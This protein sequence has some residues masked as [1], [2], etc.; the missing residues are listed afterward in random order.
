MIAVI[1]FMSSLD[2]LAC[3]R[4]A[5]GIMKLLSARAN[6]DINAPIRESGPTFKAVIDDLYSQGRSRLLHGNSERLGHDWEGTRGLA[7]YFAR[8]GLVLC[9]HWAAEN[10]KCDDPKQLSVAAS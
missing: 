3:G 10:A 7:E 5:T 1:K 9:F 4:R 8:I 2:A 6:V